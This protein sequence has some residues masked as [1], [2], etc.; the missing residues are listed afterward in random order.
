MISSNTKTPFNVIIGVYEFS[1]VNGS[2]VAFKLPSGSFRCA[3]P[4]SVKTLSELGL[5]E[6]KIILNDEF[7]K[8]LLDTLFNK[9]EYTSDKPLKSKK[10]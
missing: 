6:H 3:T 5:R 1:L 10:K 9:S 2:C 8:K 4:I 7:N